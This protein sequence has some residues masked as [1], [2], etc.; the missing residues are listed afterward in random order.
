[1]ADTELERPPERTSWSRRT[2][3]TIW[4]SIAFVVLL[5]VGLGVGLKL[6][7]LDDDYGPLTSGSTGGIGLAA[8]VRE[9]ADGF[10]NARLVTPGNRTTR[11]F[12]SLG[13]D[14]SH[15]VVVTSV[16]NDDITVG[17]QWAPWPGNGGEI[18]GP[19]TH[20]RAFP[21]TV[22]ADSEVLLRVTIRRPPH[23]QDKPMQRGAGEFYDGTHV[24]HWESLLGDH[25][26][27]IETFY[28]SEGGIQVC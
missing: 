8:G 17:A 27:T 20:W 18:F 3:L 4:A 15:S 5:A 22:R 12:S 14:G 9:D 13:N 10:S 24:V 28:F 26:T 23:C 1:M 6:T 11:V 19:Q 2:R 16:E 21:A 25:T 7:A